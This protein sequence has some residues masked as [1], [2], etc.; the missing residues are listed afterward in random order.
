M[1]PRLNCLGF[2]KGRANRPKQGNRRAARAF[3][4]KRAASRCRAGGKPLPVAASPAAHSHRFVRAARFGAAFAVGAGMILIA[5]S[6]LVVL[7]AVVA[8]AAAT[9]PAFVDPLALALV[10]G[11]TIIVSLMRGPLGDARSAL[12]SLGVATGYGRFDG[13]AARAELAG[14]DRIA[15][16]RGVL[17]LERREVH[18]P[19]LRGL[20]AAVIDGAG[21]PRVRAMIAGDLERRARRHAVV[22]DF[23]LS[24]AEVAPAMGLIGTIVGLV[25]MFGSITDPATVGPGMAIALLTT[26]YGALLA[27]VVAGPV[28][29]RL[30]RLSDA[31][32]QARLA[33]TPLLESIAA[34]QAGVTP[35]RV[36][37]AR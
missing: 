15:T 31:E 28:A 5:L 27:N 12:L 10:L 7:A 37:V 2:S 25:Q 9:A 6:C 8:I 20:I 14:L 35:P 18:D 21:P 33:L 13:D 26:L 34:Q 24:V 30:G 16:A 11:G 17:A 19:A 29:A 32:H 4:G 1:L 23:W 22:Q 36:E 3:A